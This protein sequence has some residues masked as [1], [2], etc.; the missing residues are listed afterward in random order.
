MD[1]YRFTKGVE[2]LVDPIEVGSIHFMQFFNNL[3]PKSIQKKLVE[4]SSSK[5]S[6]M[7]FIIDPYAYF[8]CYEI[9]NIEYAKEL[10]PKGF[11]LVKAKIFEDDEPKYY[12]IFGC[13]N[14]RTSAFLGLR[15]E[16]YI[17]AED[18]ETG[19]LSWIIIDYDSNTISYDKKKGLSNP[20]AS[21][22]HITTH[23]DGT[24][25]TS[26]V[27]KE[28]N[29]SLIFD[30]DLKEGVMKPLDQRLWLEG[31]LSIGYG[32]NI[33]GD[34]KYIFS[35]KFD[36]NEVKEALEIPLSSLDL[37]FNNWYKD[38]YKETPSKLVCFPYA[39]HFISDSPGFSSNIKNKE[40]LIKVVENTDF[41]QIKVI[42]TKIFKYMFLVGSITSFIVTMALLTLLILK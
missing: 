8:L 31:N 11:S 35:L 32:R 36:P 10:L 33:V 41:N 12:G 5:T 7:G 18:D 30:S 29:R 22:S 39:Q 28:E 13:V 17:M 3:M 26:V 21:N 27:N 23:Y 24:L 20:N 19:L 38:L 25:V 4:N 37:K 2:R 6:S 1:K 14:A 42:D 15:V 9:T 16:F 34:N 40:E